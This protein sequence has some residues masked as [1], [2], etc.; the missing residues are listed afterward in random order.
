MSPRPDRGIVRYLRVDAQGRLIPTRRVAEHACNRVVMHDLWSVMR[1][2]VGSL[3]EV[4]RLLRQDGGRLEIVERQ[5]RIE[6]RELVCLLENNGWDIHS[7]G[8]VGE[9]GYRL[10]AAVCDESVTS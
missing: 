5:S 3:R 7:S 10:E 4:A 2:P 8:K 9:D 1:D 6:F